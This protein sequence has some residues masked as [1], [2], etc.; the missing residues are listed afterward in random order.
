[1]PAAHVSD[2]VC[3]RTMTTWELAFQSLF[4][5]LLINA[6]LHGGCSVGAVAVIGIAIA[7]PQRGQF[8][9]HYISHLD[10]IR[11]MEHEIHAGIEERLA[12]RIGKVRLNSNTHARLAASLDDV[13]N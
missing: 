9:V 1:V 6:R 10:H 7:M 8:G 5:R 3:R 13:F 12:K 4:A 11:Q 2:F